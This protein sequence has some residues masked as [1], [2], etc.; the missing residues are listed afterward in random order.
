MRTGVLIH[1]TTA[2]SGRFLTLPHPRTL[3]PTYYLF[4]SSS[5]SSSSDGELYELSTLSDSKFD[6][7]WMISHL[8][9]VI[10][11]GQLDILSRVDARFLVVSLLYNVLGGDGKYRSREDTFE[12]IALVLQ[13][14]RS[15]R[16]KQ[17]IPEMKAAE[18]TQE[19]GEDGLQQ[20]WT[21]IVAFGNLPLIK[22]ALEDVADVQGAFPFPNPNNAP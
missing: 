8:N 18:A 17:A 7:S 14:Q 22:K 1:P 4:S 9:Q 15:E 5:D 13:A 6:R 10:S 21:D 12:Q 11:S 19:E 2:R 16:M 3:V 20:E